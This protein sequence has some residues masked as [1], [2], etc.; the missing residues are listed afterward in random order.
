MDRVRK[1]ALV[2]GRV[3][4]V[5]FRATCDRVASSEGVQC[6]ATNLDDG[7]VEVLL[8]G[9][10][11]AVSRV[12]EWCHKGPPHAHVTGVEVTDA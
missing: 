11:D 9:A 4:G 2:S 7:R 8:E 12:I 10:P 1:R 5:F 3:Q 6:R